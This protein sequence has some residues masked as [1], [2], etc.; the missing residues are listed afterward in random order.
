MPTTRSTPTRSISEKRTA[1]ST[2]PTMRSTPETRMA[3]STMPTTRSISETRTA[4]NITPAMKSTMP[5]MI[6][7]LLVAV[8]GKRVKSRVAI[9]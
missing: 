2:M 1:E 5:T 4:K 9:K 6:W 7:H 8:N 3:K